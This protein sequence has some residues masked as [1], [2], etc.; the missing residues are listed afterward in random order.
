[1]L[2]AN[3]IGNKK[4]KET[5][6]YNKYEYSQADLDNALLLMQK[7]TTLRE[8]SRL[9]NI[10]KSTL[11]LKNRGDRE[12][13]IIRPGPKSILSVEEENKIV[14]WILER[15]DAKR[16]IT[17]TQLLDNV[18]LYLDIS[19]RISPFTDN[20]PGRHWFESFLKRHS[21]I[22]ERVSQNLSDARN[23]ATEGKIRTWFAEVRNYLELKNLIDVDP[24]RVFNCE[25]AFFL[26]PNG[27]RVL[28][29]RGSKVVHKVVDG[30][31]KESLTVLYTISA[32][33]DLASPMILYWYSRMPSE[34]SSQIPK[35]NFFS[36]YFYFLN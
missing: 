22:S 14:M 12:T 36:Y 19:R 16:P 31:D 7:G 28:A 27:D 33:G 6:T 34:V 29:R 1:M 2:K 26:N 21:R 18:K 3:S 4:R 8:A 20:R 17:K 25:S 9:Y 35:R 32:A 15:F 30:S 23:K 5:K 24:S 13:M 10:P 11:S